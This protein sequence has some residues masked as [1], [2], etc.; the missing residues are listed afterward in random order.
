LNDDLSRLAL[1]HSEYMAQNG[2]THIG[3]N[4]LSAKQRIANAGYGAAFPVEN[5]FDG[6][7]SINDAWDY[8]S[9][10]PPHVDNLLTRYNTV[11]GIGIYKDEPMTY[12][13]QDFGK[14]AQ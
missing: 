11:I 14:P 8:W 10:D 2:I 13:T 1:A 3:A 7:A 5:I 9:T 6:Q 4:G 12:Y